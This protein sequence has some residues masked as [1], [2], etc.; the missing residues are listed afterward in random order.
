VNWFSSSKQKPC[1]GKGIACPVDG[2]D[3]D[4]S[5]GPLAEHQER[6]RELEHQTSNVYCG[7]NIGMDVACFTEESI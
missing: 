3:S 4:L 5:A 7:L 6:L 2:N 1:T